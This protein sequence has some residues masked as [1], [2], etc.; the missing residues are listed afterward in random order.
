MNCNITGCKK[1]NYLAGYLLLYL[2]GILFQ[3]DLL[4]QVKTVETACWD[5]VKGDCL[6][7]HLI[8][9]IM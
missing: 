9:V 4:I 6:C 2:S 3:S 1:F 7:H 5:L 8:Q